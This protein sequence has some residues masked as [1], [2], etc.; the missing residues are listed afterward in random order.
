M[1]APPTFAANLANFNDWLKSHPVGSSARYTRRRA[2]MFVIDF[3][4]DENWQGFTDDVVHCSAAAIAGAELGDLGDWCHK[5]ERFSFNA[6]ERL[7]GENKELRKQY[8]AAFKNARH[9]DFLCI[10][11]NFVG[12]EHHYGRRNF[13]AVDEVTL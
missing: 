1:T 2:K 13:C 8:A 3:E 12:D 6:L 5:S 7:C 10:T 9:G 11:T 4:S